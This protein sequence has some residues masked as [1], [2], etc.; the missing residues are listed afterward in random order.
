MCDNPSLRD[1]VA[2]LRGA[3]DGESPVMGYPSLRRKAASLV[4][5][6]LAPVANAPFGKPLRGFC[7]R[8]CI[9]LA[10]QISSA[11]LIALVSLET[12]FIFFAPLRGAGD[13]ESSVMGYPSLRRKAASLVYPILAPVATLP[14]INP[15]GVFDLTSPSDAIL[16][17]RLW[18]L[19]QTPTGFCTNIAI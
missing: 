15:C 7:A 17:P 9:S 5:P 11:T 4:Y 18:S 6:I 14:L 16:A 12:N 1:L 19:W 10:K 8:K 2:P 13:G 3:G